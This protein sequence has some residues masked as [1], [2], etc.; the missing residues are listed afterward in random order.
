MAIFSQW[1]RICWNTDINWP[2][3]NICLFWGWVGYRLRACK[4]KSQVPECDTVLDTLHCTEL[5]YHTQSFEWKRGPFR[6]LWMKCCL[7]C[8]MC[9]FLG[10]HFL[11]AWFY[12]LPH[13]Y[14]YGQQ[15]GRFNDA[16]KQNC[17][18]VMPPFCLRRTV[19]IT[20]HAIM[21]IHHDIWL[22]YLSLLI[23]YKQLQRTGGAHETMMTQ[24]A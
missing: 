12:L 22:L 7:T 13:W 20:Q 18:A 6:C 17:S 5:L 8:F 3:Y 4:G 19:D 14:S 24:D 10:I 23:S 2:V 21:L 1:I 16:L 15:A 11:C 9:V